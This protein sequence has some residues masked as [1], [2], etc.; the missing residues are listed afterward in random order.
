MSAERVGGRNWVTT[1]IAIA[2][3]LSGVQHL[4]QAMTGMRGAGDPQMLIVEHVDVALF[5]F[6]AVY[7]IMRGRWW[8]PWAIAVAGLATAVLVVSLGPLLHLDAASRSGLWSGA[9]FIL[10]LAALGAWYVR[11]S[12]SS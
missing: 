9:V 10:V 4:I 11:R 3:A 12:L 6:V 2:V 1:A 5:S 7:G 8:A